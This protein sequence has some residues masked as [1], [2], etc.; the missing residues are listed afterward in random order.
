MF[1]DLDCWKL[2][3]LLL[4]LGSLV[5][6]RRRRLAIAITWRS[7]Y[8]DEDSLQLTVEDLEAVGYLINIEEV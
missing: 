1:D 3:H 7:P 8:I 4:L 5:L 6:Y 2:I